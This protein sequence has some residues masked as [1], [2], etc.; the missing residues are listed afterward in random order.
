MRQCRNCK[1]YA[2]KDVEFDRNLDYCKS[3]MVAYRKQ[4][5]EKHK[6]K[7][8]ADAKSYYKDNYPAIKRQRTRHRELNKER[9]AAKQ[10]EYYKA[11]KEAIRKTHAEYK[12]LRKQ[13]DSLF[14]LSENLRTLIRMSLQ[15]GGYRK[16]SKTSR[17]LG[18]DFATVQTHLINSAV[19]NYGEHRPEVK[20]HI[21]HIIPCS[22]A[23]TEEELIRLQHYT[24]LQLLYPKDNITKGNKLDFQ[25][26]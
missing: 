12:K 13:T 6:E 8:I 16:T 11:N 7:A 23:T 26:I 1:V 15:S 17:L 2:T 25:L 24:N 14:K 19:R 5:Y 22:S 4:Y 3:C 18:A 21:D 20:Y 9:I 10:S